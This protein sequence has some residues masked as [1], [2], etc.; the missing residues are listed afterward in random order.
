MKGMDISMNKIF[1]RALCLL[2]TGCLSLTLCSCSD[3]GKKY[4]EM[5][6]SKY[7]TLGEYKGIEASV[8]KSNFKVTDE[9]IQRVVEKKFADNIAYTEIKKRALKKDDTVV[10]DC[11]GK[12]DGKKVDGCSSQDQTLK[13]GSTD[14][15]EAED[16]LIGHY[17][18]D[19]VIV[20]AKFPDTVSDEMLKGKDVEYTITIKSAKVG[21]LPE[22]TDNLVYEVTGYENYDE[23][24][25]S[26]R[27]E[28]T[29]FYEK[30]LVDNAK[31]QI[32]V[33][34]CSGSKLI[35]NPE[36]KFLDAKD[37]Y[38]NK[39]QKIAEQY[40]VGIDEMFTDYLGY[41]LDE[42]EQKANEYAAD[43]VFEDMVFYSIVNKEKLSL[44]DEEYNTAAKD[45]VKELNNQGSNY[46]DVYALEADKGYDKV[47]EVLLYQ[48]MLQFLY[49]NGKV[50]ITE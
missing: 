36:Q 11:I 37:E 4:S 29:E 27:K 8:S 46:A 34:V 14:F 33:E 20:N 40:K 15:P 18:N 13:I 28:M 30:A 24:I 26:L 32:W 38:Y 16:K 48:K 42:V 1:K 21:K 44:S 43:R 31:T 17:V 47:Y 25:T 9:E 45:Y 10:I 12:I 35:K 22:F 39:Y 2:I 50:T 19:V 41:S 23:Y 6:L 5:D 7:I 3:D 49:D